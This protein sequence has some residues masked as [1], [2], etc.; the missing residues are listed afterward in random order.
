VTRSPSL[1]QEVDLLVLGA[2]AGGMTAALV[3]ALQGLQVL[4]A[5]KTAVVGGTTAISAGSIWVPGTHHSP[6]G[7]DDAGTARRYLQAAIGDRL[8]AAPTEAFLAAGPEMV[9]FL[10]QH[11][12]V[13]LRAYPYHP[14]YLADLPGAT[15]CGRV[16]EPLPFDA[17]VLG[18]ELARLRPPMPEFT[19]LG[20][21]M[22]DRTDIGHLLGATRSVASARHAARLLLRYGADRLRHP[23]GTRL[24]MGNALAG[25]LFHSLLQHGVPVLTQA[26]AIELALAD[27]H[28]TGATLGL[29]E[30]STQVR[31]RLGVVLA[32]GGFS[33]HPELR[34][35]LLPEPLCEHSPL[36]ESVTGDGVTL[37]QKAGGHLGTGHANNSFWAPVSVRARSDGSTAVFPHFVLD[38]GKPGLIAVNREGRRFVNEATT[39]QRFAEAMYAAHAQT[40]TIPC[41]LICD[42]RCM[43]SYGLGMVR[44]RRL[45]LRHAIADGY[46]V[47]ANT[48]AG[49][50]RMLGIEPAALEHTV[51]RYNGFAAGGVDPDFGK[52]GDAYQRNLGDPAHGPN[53]CIGPIQAPPFY[54]IAVWP[55]DIG[56]SCGLVTDEGARVLR[57]D[58][59]PVEGL[60]AVGNDMDSIMAGIYP[61]PGVT[62]GPA[63]TFGYLAARH[64]TARSRAQRRGR[65]SRL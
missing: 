27:G 64:A 30:G 16:L 8:R 54:A 2:G 15:L 41:H 36:V 33:R 1:P 4:L 39:Y 46:V 47:R 14:D 31:S 59:T 22:V 10:E 61:A 29:Q 45:N 28:V 32:T 13:R 9:R 52:G 37:G 23:R 51:A 60:Y 62:L 5:E 24:V 34:R 26:A 43:V 19:L 49:L 53:P 56:A 20:G 58:G 11:T 63:M 42:D 44:P 57:A 7:G 50:A 12:A 55:G 21:M 40:P 38:R 35:Q 48:I 3:A 25:R 17:R 6:P 65:L 18:R